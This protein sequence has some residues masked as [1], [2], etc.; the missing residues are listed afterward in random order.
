MG[1]V[2]TIMYRTKLISSMVH[3][4]GVNRWRECIRINL[5]CVR[6]ERKLSG[7]SVCDTLETSHIYIILIDD[8]QSNFDNE[9][10]K[11]FWFYYFFKWGL[12]YSNSSFYFVLHI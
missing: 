7:L 3:N 1:K 4:F 11:V 8:L 2:H 12:I 5:Q 10:K 9:N 6:I